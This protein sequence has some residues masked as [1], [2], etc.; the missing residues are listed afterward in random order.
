[1]PLGNK[2]LN[3]EN[4]LVCSFDLCPLLEAMFYSLYVSSFLGEN[5]LSIVKSLEV[6]CISVVENVLGKVNWGH[7][8]HLYLGGTVIGAFT[9]S[10]TVL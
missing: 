10:N 5:Y 2:L 6:I 4:Y 9:V 1:M 3:F 7:M 8:V